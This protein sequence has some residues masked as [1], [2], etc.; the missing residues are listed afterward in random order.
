M[1]MGSWNAHKLKPLSNPNEQREDTRGKKRMMGTK[2][3]WCRNNKFMN[4]KKYK[5]MACL[6]N[7]D[8]GEKRGKR[9]IIKTWFSRGEPSK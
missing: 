8:G 3:K 6:G 1:D 2:E 5:K 9:R 4:N 7:P